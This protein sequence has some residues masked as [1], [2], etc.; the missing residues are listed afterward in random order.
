VEHG[1]EVIKIVRAG[2]DGD[3]DKLRA[4]AKLLI[5]KLPESD[6]SRKAIQNILDGKKSME[7]RGF[8]SYSFLK[9]ID[10]KCKNCN[11][12]IITATFMETGET[13]TIC[14][15]GHPEDI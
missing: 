1:S 13:K 6:Y 8:G 7:I 3:K 11:S 5:S 4:Y 14:K 12:L 9:G 10:R 2:I 15:C